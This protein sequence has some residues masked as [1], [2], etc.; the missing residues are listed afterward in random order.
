MSALFGQNESSSHLFIRGSCR[1]RANQLNSVLRSSQVEE[2]PAGHELRLVFS[3]I[4][5]RTITSSIAN[6]SMKL[7]RYWGINRMQKRR[8]ATESVRPKIAALLFTIKRLMNT[9]NDINDTQLHECRNYMI[10][11]VSIVSATIQI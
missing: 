5:Q 7:N 1:R 8:R 3:F 9:T 6:S 2:I 11:T 10:N 4:T